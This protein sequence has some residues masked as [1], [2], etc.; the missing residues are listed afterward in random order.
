MEISEATGCVGAAQQSSQRS[1][2]WKGQGRRQSRCHHCG[3][4]V[5]HCGLERHSL[6]GR[7]R[8]GCGAASA[9]GKEGGCGT[10]GFEALSL[11]AQGPHPGEPLG[12][13]VG[14]LSLVLESC[15][16]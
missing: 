10:E 6:Q 12:A 2:G 4:Q 14:A 9:S 5:C 8:T 11:E 13:G 1:K 15:L 3:A 7:V 16:S